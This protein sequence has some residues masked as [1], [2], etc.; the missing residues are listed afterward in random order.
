MGIFY[1]ASGAAAIAS[2]VVAGVLWDR[3]DPS[4]PFWLGAGVAALAVVML[5][6]VR[7]T[8]RSGPQ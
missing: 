5:V 6:L 7:A 1:F 3:V 8:V 2:S 4:A